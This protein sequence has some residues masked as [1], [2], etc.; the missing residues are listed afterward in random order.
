MEKAKIKNIYRNI[1]TFL[2]NENKK[3]QISNISKN[4]RNRDYFG[5]VEWL[6]DAG[7]INICYCLKNACLPLKSNYEESK[8]KIYFHD[9]GLLMA[10]LDEES[11]ED[12]R[13]NKN[14]GTFKGAIYENLVAQMLKSSGFDLYYY[15]KE[16]SQL[17][18]DFFVR[19]SESLIPVEVKAKDGATISLNNLITHQTY[20]DVKF[21][22]KLSQKNIGFNGRFYTV[23]YFCTFLLKRFL[24]ED[25]VISTNKE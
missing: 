20:N 9:N 23:P 5:C 19:T 3:F 16:N 17:E 4:A 7:I 15:K 11:S 18:M 22:I 14:I 25:F 6:K 1:P 21:G 24:K 12:L 10:S 2:A 13:K 8:Y